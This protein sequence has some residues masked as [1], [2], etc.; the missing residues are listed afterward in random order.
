MTHYLWKYWNGPHKTWKKTKTKQP[1]FM[2]KKK[3]NVKDSAIT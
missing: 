1:N 3:Y 2:Q